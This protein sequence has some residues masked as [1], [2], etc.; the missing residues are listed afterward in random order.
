MVRNRTAE[1]V[2]TALFKGTEAPRNG[3]RVWIMS[4]TIA[5]VIPTEATLTYSTNSKK[6]TPH[7]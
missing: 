3:C 4:P 5:T 1:V 2:Q 7:C 6:T